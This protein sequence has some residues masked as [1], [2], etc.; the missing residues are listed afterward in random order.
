MPEDEF[1][2]RWTVEVGLVEEDEEEGASLFFAKPPPISIAAEY[3]AYISSYLSVATTGEDKAGGSIMT[4]PVCG[5]S[6]L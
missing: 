3:L 5:M 2:R 1:V 4:V 6:I